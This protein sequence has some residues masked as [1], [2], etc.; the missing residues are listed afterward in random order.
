MWASSHVFLILIRENDVQ[1][2][3]EIPVIGLPIL[4]TGG[5]EY[6][7]LTK[8]MQCRAFQVPHKTPTPPQNRT[9]ILSLVTTCLS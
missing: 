9:V 4:K 3:K 1:P 8:S 2:A 6:H 7:I 5:L